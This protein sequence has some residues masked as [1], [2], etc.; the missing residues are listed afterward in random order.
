MAL[1]HEHVPDLRARAGDLDQSTPPYLA[2]TAGLTVEQFEDEVNNASDLLALSGTS[3]MPELEER[4]ET[5]EPMRFSRWRSWH[6]AFASTS[7]RMPW[8]WDGSMPS[9]SVEASA[10]A[11]RD[12]VPQS[13]A[14]SRCWASSWTARR[15]AGGRTGND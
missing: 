7:A 2:R 14:I 10:S 11:V 5:G 15:T 9:S 6:T 4:C 3:D 1:L 8:R 13:S 12:S